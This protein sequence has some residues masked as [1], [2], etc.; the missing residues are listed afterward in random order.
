VYLNLVHDLREGI[1]IKLRCKVETA[2]KY[3]RNSSV[4]SS[5]IIDTGASRSAVTREK[6]KSLGYGKYVKE[7]GKKLTANGETEFFST[8]IRGLI[9]AEQF[10]LGEMKVDVLE[11]WGKR[12][13][14]GVIGMDILTNL[15]FIISH[16]HSKFIITNEEIPE[17]VGIFK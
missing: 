2:N 11:G 14:V 17:L 7:P 10:S 3:I 9:V 5:F 8:I 15:T 16:S 12:E 4:V 1:T 13:I 6:L